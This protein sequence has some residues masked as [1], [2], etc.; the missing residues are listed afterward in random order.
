MT[1]KYHSDSTI[2]HRLDSVFT[3][4]FFVAIE[5]E[6][7]LS[8][9][10]RVNNFLDQPFDVLKSTLISCKTA[11][12]I[13]RAKL[14]FILYLLDLDTIIQKRDRREEGFAYFL[15]FRRREIVDIFSDIVSYIS[16]NV[17]LSWLECDDDEYDLNVSG[18]AKDLFYLLDD[19][20]NKRTV[21]QNCVDLDGE[22]S[23]RWM[24]LLNN[25][26]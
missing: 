6:T 8:E 21:F 17:K 12:E 18:R 19:A 15:E 10:K 16:S 25:A 23:Q 9:Y 5:K 7:E 1:N 13:I 20:L 26:Q 11:D 22:I 3:E 24:D 2:V 14:T 4:K